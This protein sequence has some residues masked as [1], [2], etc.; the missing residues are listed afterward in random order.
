[1]ERT[2][3]KLLVCGHH[4]RWKPFLNKLVFSVHVCLFEIDVMTSSTVPQGTRYSW[5]NI[6]FPFDLLPEIVGIYPLKL[7]QDMARAGPVEKGLFPCVYISGQR[8]T[9]DVDV[10]HAAAS[11]FIDVEERAVI[12]RL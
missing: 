1:M 6:V 9:R 7:W 2:G 4:D 3:R 5:G 8:V 10:S 11:V 12:D